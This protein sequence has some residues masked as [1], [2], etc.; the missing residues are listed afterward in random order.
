[1]VTST[2][3]EAQLQ[4]L[5]DVTVR[6]LSEYLEEVLITLKEKERD[7][8][9]IISKWGCDGSQQSQ[10]KQ[11]LESNIDSDS[12]IFQSCFVPFQLVSED[13]NGNVLWNNPTP[14]SPRFCR[15]I[16]FRFIKETNYVTEEEITHVKSA[17]TSLVPTEVDLGGKK[18]LI[19]HKFI[20]AM[21]DG[22]VCN[23]ATGTK[24]TSR[25]YICGATWKD[26]NKLDYKGEVNFTALEFGISVLHAR[27]RL[28]ECILHLAYKLKVKKYRER[29][30]KEE[31]NLEDQTKREIQ[32]KF[33]SETGLLICLNPISGIQMMEIL[34][35]GYFDLEA[36]ELEELTRGQHASDLRYI[37]RRKRLS[38]FGVVCK[39]R[40]TTSCKSL[41]ETIF[42]PKRFYSA[43]RKQLEKITRKRKRTIFG[44]LYP[45]FK[46][47]INLGNINIIEKFCGAIKESEDE[48][49][50]NVKED[51]TGYLKSLEKKFQRYFHELIERVLLTKGGNLSVTPQ[52]IPTE[53]IIANIEARIK[54]VP[55][56]V[57][58][59]V[60]SEFARILRKAKPPR[61]EKAAIRSLNEYENII[62]IP[63]DKGN[64]TVV[65]NTSECRSKL[66]DLVNQDTYKRV[67]KDPTR[68]F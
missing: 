1:M 12:S 18:L 45:R 35:E 28:F 19:K 15:P 25:S 33:R 32:T 14:S 24:S 49:N 55:P 58:E 37:E 29:K 21:V 44:H 65:V 10:F 51:I 53:E 39:K 27:I 40:T 56:D 46:N 66:N 5:I 6:R 48:L 11:K 64:A 4:P 7:C 54:K 23:A 59:E 34:A 31:K 36:D 8:L 3:A 30:S 63:A 67:S 13:K 38:L 57:K 20:M 26:F 17:I 68:R 47:S 42:Y 43:A 52:T 16:R 61:G 50:D 60:R 22:K 41:L 9:I 62:N 2:T